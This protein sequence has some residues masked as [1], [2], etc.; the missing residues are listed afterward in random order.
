MTD[1][2]RTATYLYLLFTLLFSAVIWTIVI[3]SGHL[4]A[5]CWGGVSV[6]WGGTGRK[7]STSPLLTLFLSRTP[8]LLMAPYGRCGWAAGTPSLLNL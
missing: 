2:P 7:V 8:Q 6:R 4:S 1:T 5:G 3:W